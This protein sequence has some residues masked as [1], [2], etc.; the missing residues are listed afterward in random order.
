MEQPELPEQQHKQKPQWRRGVD[1]HGRTVY[2]V[3]TLSPSDA[4]TKRLRPPREWHD[5]LLGSNVPKYE[6]FAESSDGA[7][8]SFLFEAHAYEYV[9]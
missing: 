3:V 8:V 2:L 6:V 9:K 5:A 1:V 4:S 7:P